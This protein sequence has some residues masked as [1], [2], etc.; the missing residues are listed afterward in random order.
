MRLSIATKVFMGFI[1]VMVLFGGVSTYSLIRM[2]QVQE[3]LRVLNRVYL[4]LNEA[5]VQLNL[6]MTEVHTLQ[7]NLI[8]LLDS[9]PEGR[10]PVMVVRWIRMARKHRIKRISQAI[11]VARHAATLTPPRRDAVFIEHLIKEL[12]SIRAGFKATDPLYDRLFDHTQA[13]P[14]QPLPAQIQVTGS[15][16]RRHEHSVFTTLRTLSNQ[17]RQRLSGN[18]V[19]AVLR[20]A[21]RLERTETRAFYATMVWV[22]LAVIVGLILTWMSQLTLRPLAKLADDARRVARGEY[23]L[24]IQVRSHDEVGSLAREFKQ[25]ADALRERE[26]RLIETERIAA[27]SERM[28]V[29]GHLAAQITHEI[30]NPLS[31]I[32]LNAEMLEEEL[33]QTDLDRDTVDLTRRI[34][35]EVD[36][37]TDI[38]EEYLQFA[39]LPRPKLDMEQPD[40]VV[41]QTCAL[42]QEDFSQAGVQIIIQAAPDLPTIPMDENQIRQAVLNIIKNAKEAMDRGGTIQVHINQTT[43][44]QGEVTEGRPIGSI[45][46]IEIRID[47]DG[48]GIPEESLQQLF[49]P[50]YSTKDRGTGLGLAITAQIISEHGG[51]LAAANAPE[52]GASFRILIPQK[53]KG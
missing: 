51:T 37:L 49:E 2:H 38:T 19:P 48:P 14:G 52:G 30:R 35:K 44:P 13:N 3:D 25:M 50:F 43:M 42:V 8:N 11:R 12:T 29:M 5:Y 28:A 46:A 22:V 31:A 10:N 16:L 41:R 26:R 27:R 6:T 47:D 33:S 1:A 18:L 20:T 40:E 36:R 34:Q 9:M 4:R 39:R 17:L 23:E 15:G 53:Q 45:P 32:G 21:T 7:N 24:D